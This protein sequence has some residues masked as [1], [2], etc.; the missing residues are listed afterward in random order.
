MEFKLEIKKDTYAVKVT[1]ED[2]DKIIG[3]GFLYVIFQDRHAEPYGL[4]ENIYIEQ[5]YRSQGIG[6]QVMSKLIQ[7]A[8]DRGCYKLICTSKQ[9]NEK[10]HIFYE[11]F[12]LKKIGYE[13]RMDLISSQSKQRD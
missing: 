8:K 6:T 5:E 12:G 13:F 1:A 3:W 2:G 10:A 9:E 7:E 11:R 4:L